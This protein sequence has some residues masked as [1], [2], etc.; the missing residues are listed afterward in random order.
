MRSRS[1][2]PALVAEAIGTFTL[3][4]AGCGAIAVGGL[5]PTGV[6]AAFGLAIMTMIYA[7][8]HVSGAH[9]NPAVTAAFALGRHF[10]VARVLP[11]WAAQ[12]VGAL[13][14]AALLRATLGDVP[15]GVTHPLG[16]DIQA[17]VWEVVLTFFLMLVIVAVAT[18]TRA[19]GQAAAIAIGG[20]VAL[21]ALVG[22]P[23]SGASMNPARSLGPAFV[24]GDLSDLW[25]YLVGPPVGAVAA[26]VVY[27]Y[28][29]SS[30]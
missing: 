24:S 12:V 17:L 6:A 15:L 3:V 18:D 29:H 7:L 9:F 27:R 30:D 2:G 1:L 22:G 20:T 28:L 4:F 16:S 10:P 25:I 14:G 5:G 19:V 13:A 11:Y 21:A 26:A 23:I 8:G